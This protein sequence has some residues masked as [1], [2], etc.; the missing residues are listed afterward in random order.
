MRFPC[1]IWSKTLP[2]VPDTMEGPFSRACFSITI[3]CWP[4]TA[5]VLW[6]VCLAMS[7][8]SF[9]TCTASSLVGTSTKPWGPRSLESII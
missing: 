3:L 5:V 1:L 8:K 7:F 2:G 4:Y 9:S 6:A